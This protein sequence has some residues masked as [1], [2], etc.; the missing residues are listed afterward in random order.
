MNQYIAIRVSTLR[1]D[2][3]IPFNAYVQVAG[4]F[5][6]FCREGDSF[7]GDRLE[8]LKSKKLKKMYIPE[9]QIEV[10][11]SYI[12]QNVENAY[13]KS[14]EKSVEVRAQVIHGALQATAEDLIDDP[15]S[16]AHYTVALEAAKKFKAFLQVEPEA[17]KPIVELTN[18]DFNIS[19]HGV[20]VAAL[21]LAIACEM[22]LNESRPMELEAMA[23]GC[24]IHDIENSYNNINLSVPPEKLTKAE[25][26]IY[27]KH[28]FAAHERLKKSDFYDPVILDVVAK[29]DE[30]LDG[31]GPRKLKE[32]DLDQ[33]S[34]I[35]A[36][37][38]AFDKLIMYEKLPV[39][40]ALK[41][42]LIDKMGLLNLNCMKALQSA[43]KKCGTI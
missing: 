17:L 12:H 37:A 10:Y 3:K 23:L 14:K 34:M 9:E 18:P 41:K 28:T 25:K 4:K 15:E 8:R 36:T 13:A 35:V 16:F 31:S 21:A 2:L 40:E 5:I 30:K 42:L 39:K 32:R 1:G 19:H 22:N 26:I 6:L 7:E 20:T 27:E 43:L 29:H 33:I 24:M 11:K 38:N